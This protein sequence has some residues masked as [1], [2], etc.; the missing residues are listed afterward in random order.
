MAR[1]I[2]NR[3][4]LLAATSTRII[5]F[6]LFA[7]FFSSQWLLWFLPFLILQI[8][9]GTQLWMLV[10]FG[11]FMCLYFPVGYGLRDDY[12]LACELFSWLLRSKLCF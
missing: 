2:K 7:K 8:H 1:G 12:A 4:V 5:R 11:F 6:T 9:T 3:E 10:I